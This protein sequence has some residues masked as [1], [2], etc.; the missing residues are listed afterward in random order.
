VEN[1]GST[2]HFDEMELQQ[3]RLNRMGGFTGI[4][5]GQQDYQGGKP[6]A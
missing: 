6:E 1:N 4:K 5:P 3:L 2:F